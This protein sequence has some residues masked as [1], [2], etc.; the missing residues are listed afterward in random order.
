MAGTAFAYGYLAILMF[1]PFV[2]LERGAPPWLPGVVM[3]GSAVLAPL[4]VRLARRHVNALPHTTALAGGT[5][6]LAASPCKPAS[7]TTSEPSW[8]NWTLASPS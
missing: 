5:A 3:T 4:T 7:T 1:M 6:L 8:P 2:L